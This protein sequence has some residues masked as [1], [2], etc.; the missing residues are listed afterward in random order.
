M[1][2]G[3][4]GH[5]RE[6]GG[7]GR[8]DDGA[9]SWG[10]WGINA[11]MVGVVVGMV[12]HERGDGGCGRGNDGAWTWEWLG[13]DVGMTGRGWARVGARQRRLVDLWG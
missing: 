4:V 8:G 2:V 13:V 11:R 7:C 9:W 1:V 6:D 5:E 10:W 3:M 12:G